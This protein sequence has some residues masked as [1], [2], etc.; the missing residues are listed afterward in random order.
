[1]A[2]SIHQKIFNAVKTRFQGIRIDG[3]Y[4]TEIGAH[5]FA[6]R[7]FIHSPL[8]PEEMPGFSLKDRQVEPSG[9]P[10]TITRHYH[11]ISFEVQAMASATTSSPPDNHARRIIADLT[12]AIGVDRK[13]TT[14]SVAIAID[15]EPGN[16]GIESVHLG[17]RVVFIRYEFTVRF[18]TGIFDPYTQ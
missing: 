18:R 14:D 15:T 1:M 16:A 17:D 2:D 12:K 8:A 5:A 11:E 13:W 10:E 4:E 7:D 9:R 3:G 6:W